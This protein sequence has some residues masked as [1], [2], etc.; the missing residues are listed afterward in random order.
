MAL[1]EVKGFIL[2]FRGTIY[3]VTIFGIKFKMCA[4]ACWVYIV[5][6]LYVCRNHYLQLTRYIFFCFV[7]KSLTVL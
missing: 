3:G 2:Q 4:L 5:V 7:T 1:M 6:G